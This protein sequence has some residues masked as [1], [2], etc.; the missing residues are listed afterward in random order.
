[1]SLWPFLSEHHSRARSLVQLA[2]HV[3]SSLPLHHALL[4]GNFQTLQRANVVG[5]LTLEKNMLFSFPLP[6]LLLLLLLVERGA[7]QH[8]DMA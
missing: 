3:L 1:M 7:D 6:L 2:A 8:F 5:F 4:R